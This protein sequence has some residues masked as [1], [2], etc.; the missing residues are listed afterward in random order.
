MAFGII[1]TETV[2]INDLERKYRDILNNQN[3]LSDWVVAE[4]RRLQ[5]EIHL[6]EERQDYV[7][8]HITDVDGKTDLLDFLSGGR[9]CGPM[10]F[11]FV[12]F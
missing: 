10:A 6:L 9:V 2:R 3:G 5:G 4:L 12:G 7:E 11:A 8:D 1:G